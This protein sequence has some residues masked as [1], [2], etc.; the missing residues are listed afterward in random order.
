MYSTLYRYVVQLVVFYLG[1]TIRGFK[2]QRPKKV[3]PASFFQYAIFYLEMALK[4]NHPFLY[5]LFSGSERHEILTMAMF[6]ALYHVLYMVS[7]KHTAC[8]PRLTIAAV[9]ELRLLREVHPEIANCALNVRSRHLE[10]VSGSLVIVALADNSLEDWKKEAM[11]TK[12]ISLKH[13]WSPRQMPLSRAQPP[14]DFVWS[15]E[16][17]QENNEPSLDSLVNKDSFLFLDHLGWEKEDLEVFKLSYNNW[18]RSSPKF[19]KLYQFLSGLIFLND[20][21]ERTIKLMKDT[22]RSVHD[23][24]FLQ[25]LI[26]TTEEMR[27]RCGNFRS[28]NYNNAKLQRAIRSMLRIDH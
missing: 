11:G 28:N 9:R 22:I 18:R 24:G 19:D 4:L 27:A 1:G 14:Q 6:V 13:L 23:E 15:D 7:S 16:M 20:T 12:L 10:T 21:A 8:T 17:W 26:M 2:F 3:N 25:N 5:E